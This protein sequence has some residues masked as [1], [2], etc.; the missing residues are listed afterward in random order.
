MTTDVDAP[1]SHLD[2]LQRPLFGHLCTIRPDG[3]PQSS[4]MWFHWNGHRLRFTHRTDRQKYDNLR[5]DPRVSLSIRDPDRPYRFL[6]VRG[7]VES[8]DRD[9]DAAF[10]VELQHRYGVSYPPYDAD[11]NARVIITIA[12]TRFI[13]VDNG[14][15]PA[16]LQRLT[17]LLASLTDDPPAP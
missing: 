4:V 7:H 5:R 9:P 1:A 16:E 6:E 2:L 14:M 12:P 3:S 17:E 15:T 11:T 13:T 10:F 8:I